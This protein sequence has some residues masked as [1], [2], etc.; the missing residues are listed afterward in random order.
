MLNNYYLVFLL[1]LSPASLFADEA[2]KVIKLKAE[3]PKLRIV[4]RDWEYFKDLPCDKADQ[5]SVYSQA[6]KILLAK[7]KSQCINQYGVFFSQPLER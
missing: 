1:L 5:L 2:L 6:E 4:S 7:R 3:L